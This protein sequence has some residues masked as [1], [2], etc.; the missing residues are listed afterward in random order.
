MK[1]GQDAIYYINGDNAD[2]LLHSPHLEGFKARDIE[3]L[4]LTD[5]VDDFWPGAAI[6]YMGKKFKSATRAG[7]DLSKLGNAKETTEKKPE[8]QT[9]P[10]ELDTLIALLKKTLGEQLKDVRASSRL[11]DS[12]VC[13][14]VDEGDIDIHLERFL[15]LHNQIRNNSQ[16]IL[17]I[18]PQHALIKHLAEKAHQSGAE[19]SL[20][21]IAWLLLDQARL[22]DG[23]TISDPVAFGRRLNEIMSKAMG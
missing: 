15:K 2:A 14:A 19:D 23:E 17:E 9:V 22:M 12:A 5:T 18:N 1:E 8:E 10:A 20:K 21:D 3:V 4:L 7:Q 16:R 6:E 13:L 11:T